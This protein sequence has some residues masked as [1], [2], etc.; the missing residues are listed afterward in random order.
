MFISFITFPWGHKPSS[1]EVRTTM[2]TKAWSPVE[3]A[4]LQLVLQNLTSQEWHRSELQ[5]TDLPLL[6]VWMPSGPQTL[7]F[8]IQNSIN[9]GLTFCIFI[10]APSSAAFLRDAVSVCSWAE[11]AVRQ[12]HQTACSCL[13]KWREDRQS[14]KFLTSFK[15]L[16]QVKWS[17]EEEPC[18]TK[19]RLCLCVAVQYCSEG[20][21][22][23]EY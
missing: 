6:G 3:F 10:Q 23:V 4:L 1:G 18:L 5:N 22:E 2:W 20:K 21:R 12:P 9:A 15:Q 13:W 14:E 19:G 11:E 7:K 8:W 16:S 17:E